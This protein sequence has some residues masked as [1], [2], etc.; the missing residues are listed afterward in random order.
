MTVSAHRRLVFSNSERDENA[1]LASKM[2]ALGGAAC[3]LY[4]FIH[5]TERDTYFQTPEGEVASPVRRGTLALTPSK[6]LTTRVDILTIWT[7]VI[8]AGCSLEV[9]QRQR[10][11]VHRSISS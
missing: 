9:D 7:G 3:H 10:F 8:A 4:T 5:N 1:V 11:D 6:D 2:S